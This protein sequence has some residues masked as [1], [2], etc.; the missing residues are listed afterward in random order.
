MSARTLFVVGTALLAA[1]T[2]GSLLPLADAA[3]KESLA[4]RQPSY[5]YKT[6]DQRQLRV[7]VLY[8]HAWQAGD[9][10]PCIVFF[11]GG[12]FKNGTTTQFEPQAKYFA[13]RGLV[14]LRAEYRDST[15]DQATVNI[16]L[17][18]ALSA[19]RWVRLHTSELGIDTHRI[20]ASGGSAGGF[21]A[22]AVAA[23]AELKVPGD[24]MSISPVPN[25]LVLFNPV[26]DLVAAQRPDL[27]NEPATLKD[28]SPAYHLT[29]SYPPGVILIGSEDRF[30]G[31]VQKFVQDAAKL[32]V[33]MEIEVYAGQPHAFFNKDPYTGKTAVRA[34][35]FLQSL[36]YLSAEPSVE[37]P[38]GRR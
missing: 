3:E 15:R 28:I 18:D 12:G 10:R 36:G 2:S 19:M 14:T 22:S 33:K 20:V 8:P 27:T 17:Q 23:M 21:L 37:P 25:A 31:Q 11:S 38:H 6:V 29:S 9:R 24:D 30:L 35:Q 1:W 34:D 7:D 4:A 13:Q 16:C 32:G 26:V 5:V